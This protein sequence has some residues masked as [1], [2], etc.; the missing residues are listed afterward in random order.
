MGALTRIR[1]ISPALLG[2]VGALFIAFMVFQDSA[3]CT[4]RSST[5]KT[6]VG[7]VN[8]TAISAT[9]YESLVTSITQ[10]MKQQ[11]PEADVDDAMVREQAWM[12]IVDNT[13]LEQE[14]QRL[15]VEVSQAEILDFFFVSPPDF[16]TS[17]FRD[18]TGQ[19]N[20]KLYRDAMTNPSILRQYVGGT[21]A[22]KDNAVAQFS[23][24]MAQTRLDVMRQKVQEAVLTAVEASAAPVSPLMVERQWLTQ[25]SV[26]DVK[27]VALPASR[28]PEAQVGAVTDDEIKAYYEKHKLA[29]VQRSTRRIK[30]IEWP[31]VASGK[32]SAAF[33][34]AAAK[35]QGALSAVGDTNITGRDSIF[36]RQMIALN[37]VSNDFAHM[38]KLPLEVGLVMASMQPRQVFGPLTEGDGIR[39]YRLDDRRSGANPSVRASHIL[40]RFDANSKDSAKSKAEAVLARVRKG[41]DFAAVAREIGGDGSAQQGG[42]LGYFQKGAMV[43]PFEDA[44]FGMKVG[45]ISNLVESQFGYHIIKVTDRQETEI[46]YSV[47]TLRPVLSKQTRNGIYIAADNAVKDIAGGTSI[48]S[49]AARLKLRVTESPFYQRRTPIMGSYDITRYAFENPEGSTKRFETK[50]K[51]VVVVQVTAVREPGIQ[52]LEDVKDEVK[53]RLLVQKKLDK[54]KAQ[55]EQLAGALQSQGIDAV[56]SIDSTLDLRIATGVND[57]GILQGYRN[58]FV[59]THTA[60][61]APLNGVSK[62]IRGENAWF[63]MTVTNR[64]NADPSAFAAN[65][66]A[67]VEAFTKL[68]GRSVFGRWFEKVR[69][70]ADI[71]DKRFEMN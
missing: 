60:F 66:T 63:V 19:V 38:D 56:R 30:S 40:I 45:E 1:Q 54:L 52:P 13:L 67:A 25:N 33:F 61:T 10:R 65:R 21:D 51:R 26:A 16:L 55:A 11:N 2:V 17:A 47:I 6:V 57:N 31:M 9:E 59:A 70:R 3:S 8:G 49:V 62:A 37:G 7:T 23:Q 27:F 41:E 64:T 18:S 24:Q 43:K 12:T 22:D 20:W 34:A 58:E 5:A 4:Q 28:I 29:F 48:D 35:L 71:T 44:A 53:R 39:F 68:P 32:D 69:D 42:D 36:S 15:G 46:K 50:D 14:A